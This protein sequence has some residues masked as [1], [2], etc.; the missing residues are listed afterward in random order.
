MFATA[1]T[2]AYFDQIQGIQARKGEGQQAGEEVMIQYMQKQATVFTVEAEK[3]GA[4]TFF[5]P[6]S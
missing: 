3:H 1:A 4:Q 2:T 6:V 5:W